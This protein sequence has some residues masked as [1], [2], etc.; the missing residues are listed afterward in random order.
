[1]KGINDRFQDMVRQKDLL[2]LKENSDTDISRVVFNR[3]QENLE[4]QLAGKKLLLIL[5]DCWNE[6]YNDWINPSCPLEAAA[7]GILKEEIGKHVEILIKCNGLPLAAKTL[8]GLFTC[9][10]NRSDWDG[11]LNS[12]ILDLSEERCNVLPYLSPTL[13]QCFAYC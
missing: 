6:N 11:V 9:E 5:D 12:K 3:H 10:H 13:K 7:P 8:G 4:K 2:D 1:M